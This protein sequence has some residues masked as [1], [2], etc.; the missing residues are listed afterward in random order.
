M[1]R[2]IYLDWNATTPPLPEVIEAMRRAAE[3][4]WG[5][6]ASIHSHGRQARALVEDA[7]A[8][9]AKMCGGDPRDVLFTS[10]G[11]EANNLALQ[12]A[13][14]DQ[15]DKKSV[16]V[17][18]RI[19]HPSVTKT[20]EMIEKSG[21]ATV[22]WARVTSAGVVDLDDIEEALKSGGVKLVTMQEVNH[23]TG[24][25]QPVTEVSDLAQKYG[26]RMHVDSVQAFG[27]IEAR[28]R[29]GDSRAFAA[30]KIRG[31][32][33]VGALITSPCF[34]VEAMFG[35]GGQ[36]KG[37]RPGTVDP[38][39]AAGVACAVAHAIESVSAY[40]A[41]AAKR[42]RIERAL[43]ERNNAIVVNGGESVRA[44][45]ITNL[46]IPGWVGAELVAALDLEGISVSSGSACSAGTIE[47][48]P[49]ITAMV[50]A[51]R[52]A[53]SIRISL[54]EETTDDDV[55]ETIRVFEKLFSRAG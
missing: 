6:P 28:R 13:F 36:E 8:A 2:R 26:A 7:R 34:R 30:H 39:A 43:C 15:V 42:D 47:P 10:G 12:S 54:G 37:L 48:S 45:H 19:E 18:S 32:K 31:P 17:T 52:A 33:G 11:T 50:G 53:S 27:R 3:L 38:V 35:G 44:P 49:A 9:I 21:R 55:E 24:A 4:S 22:H 25:V 29:L 40:A 51:D 16:L 41:V 14:A 23:E 46:S 20:A 5:N 1:A